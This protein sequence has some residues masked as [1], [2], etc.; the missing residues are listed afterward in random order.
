[1]KTKKIDP[2]HFYSLGEIVR[3]GLIPGVNSVAKMSRIVVNDSRFNKVL[4][5]QFDPVGRMER[6]KIRGSNIILYLTQRDNG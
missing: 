1:M 2:K 3:E 4:R 5:A 6:Y